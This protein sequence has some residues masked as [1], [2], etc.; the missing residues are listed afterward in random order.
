LAHDDSLRIPVAAC[1][2][3]ERDDPLKIE[4]RCKRPPL[5]V[6]DLAAKQDIDEEPAMSARLVAQSSACA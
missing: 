6:T 5:F 3:S 2:A 1:D 4:L